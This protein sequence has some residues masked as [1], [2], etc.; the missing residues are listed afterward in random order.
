MNTETVE[1]SLIQDA[2]V[3]EI[4]F[5]PTALYAI[6]GYFSFLLALG[7]VMLVWF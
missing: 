7:T 5:P 4:V 3:K 6:G 1:K 2:G